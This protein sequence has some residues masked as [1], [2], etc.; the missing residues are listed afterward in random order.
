MSREFLDKIIVVKKADITGLQ[1]DTCHEPHGEMSGDEVKII[2]DSGA[3]LI[4]CFRS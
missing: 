4:A 1:H 3:M 2:P